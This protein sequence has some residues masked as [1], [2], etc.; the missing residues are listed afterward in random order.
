M[1]ATEH[2]G[3]DIYT[4]DLSTKKETRITTNG[5][6]SNPDIYGNNIVWSGGGIYLY[7]IS[8]KNVTTIAQDW[9]NDD[10]FASSGRYNSNPVIYGNW[11][12]YNG[13]E[14]QDI[15]NRYSIYLYDLS[16]K[17]ETTIAYS[18]NDRH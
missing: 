8:T 3:Y 11:I 1:G 17:R 18:G 4:Y 7:D 16:T 10:E 12:V 14:Y 15:F 13:N 5:S 2:E 9:Y 6:S